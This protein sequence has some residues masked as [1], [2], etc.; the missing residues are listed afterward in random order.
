[1][2][3]CVEDPPDRIFRTLF[4]VLPQFLMETNLDFTIWRAKVFIPGLVEW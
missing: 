2:K 4:V 3:S 1:M